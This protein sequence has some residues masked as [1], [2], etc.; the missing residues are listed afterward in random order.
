MNY[1]AKAIL[2]TIISGFVL[3]ICA[4][5]ASV[6]DKSFTVVLDPGHGGRSPGAVGGGVLEKEINLQIALAL[7]ALIE[8]N[9]PDVAVV[10]TRRDDRDVGLAERGAIANRADA[11]L[12]ISIHINALDNASANGTSTWVMGTEKNAAN[13]AEAMRE[14]EVIR[15]EEN[16]QETYAG[17]A[18]GSAESYIMFRL[19]QYAHFESSLQFAR[20]LQRHYGTRTPMRDR[21]A[22]QGPFL[23]LWKA[24]M[25]AVLTEVGFISNEADRRYITSKAGQAKIA[26]ALY[27][28]L[29][30]Y[31]TLVQR[32][33][34][35]PAPSP[36]PTATSRTTETKTSSATAPQARYYVQLSASRARFSTD[37][38][39]FGEYR[40]KVVEHTDGVWYRYSLGPFATRARAEDAKVEVR[41][42]GF[43][44]A[45]VKEIIE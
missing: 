16:Y 30:E 9:A 22:E 45:F 4:A 7:G 12:F 8:K 43:P 3:P 35:T 27:D 1:I 26:G 39:A 24:A 25:P 19:L 40:G 13:L 18:P 34:A 29:S 33:A 31:R 38:S 17:F 32:P 41:R 14:N 21:G 20:I 42:R 44:E 23:V 37:N 5:T 10:Y 6:G 2:T 15:Y 28:A 11:D 36:A